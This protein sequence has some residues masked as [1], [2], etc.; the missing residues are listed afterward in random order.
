MGKIEFGLIMAAIGMP[1]TL[2]S[3]WILGLLGTLLKKIFP[4][5]ADKRDV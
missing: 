3:L 4:H 1:A 5:R 2:L